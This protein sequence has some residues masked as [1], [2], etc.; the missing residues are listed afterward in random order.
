MDARDSYSEFSLTPED[1]EAERAEV[2][3]QDGAKIK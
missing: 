3:F 1:T 2:F